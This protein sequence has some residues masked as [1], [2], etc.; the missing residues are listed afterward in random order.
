MANR[1][2]KLPNLLC[3]ISSPSNKELNNDSSFV[4]HSYADSGEY[5]PSL[6]VSDGYLYDTIYKIGSVV[7][8][9]GDTE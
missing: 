2:T 4:H 6:T 1:L 7:I 3:N 5:S 9:S 8:A